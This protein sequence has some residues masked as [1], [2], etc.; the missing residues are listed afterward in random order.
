MSNKPPAK[1][2]IKIEKGCE[3]LLNF[4]GRHFKSRILE[5]G[6]EMM[7][8]TFPGKDYPVPGLNI[9]L[10]FHDDLGFYYMP[11]IVV[12][13]PQKQPGGITVKKAAE[14]KRSTHRDSFRVPTDLTARVRDHIHVRRYDAALVNIS[15]G[16]ALLRS[17]AP[18]DFNSTLEITL[19][20]PGE[21][22]YTLLGQ[23]MHIATGAR[24]GQQP[25]RVFG[26]K[27]IGIDPEIERAIVS[28]IFTRLPE[29]Y[30]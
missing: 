19:S 28:Y 8:V 9:V 14:V 15:A 29:I 26:V 1:S 27:F 20:L 2:P 5:V 22:L 6:P 4:V 13:G 11:A 25:E 21:P 10:E 12:E 7:R 17:D 18:W 24:A 16:G 23:V 30:A 3:C